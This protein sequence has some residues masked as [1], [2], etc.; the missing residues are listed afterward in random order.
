[1][2]DHPTCLSDRGGLVSWG[3][4]TA[5]LGLTQRRS[6][7]GVT[8]RGQKGAPTTNKCRGTAG[9]LQAPPPPD[10]AGVVSPGLC[11]RPMADNDNNNYYSLQLLL[12]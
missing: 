3:K 8:C 1:M 9:G 7:P 4:G 11:S 6:S 5:M 10:R 2:E 12:I